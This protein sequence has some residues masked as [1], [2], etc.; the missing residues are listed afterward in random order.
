[1][2]NERECVIQR[3]AVPA[4]LSA[5]RADLLFDEL[6]L[7]FAECDDRD[8]RREASVG[9]VSE[10]VSTVR[11]QPICAAAGQKALSSSF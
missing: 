1:M 4:A 7:A 2:G 5:D 8:A 10:G 9:S 6:V 11:G 3:R